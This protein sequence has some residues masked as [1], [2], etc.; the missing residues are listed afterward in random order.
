MKDSKTQMLHFL[1]KF[2]PP[3]HGPTPGFTASGLPPI[4]DEEHRKQSW[5]SAG[6]QPQADQPASGHCDE[7][8]PWHGVQESRAATSGGNPAPEFEPCR[9]LR[10]R[11]RP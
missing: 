8:L 2:P 11:P 6:G 3:F 7:I 5:L 10:G 4:S 1:T 9:D